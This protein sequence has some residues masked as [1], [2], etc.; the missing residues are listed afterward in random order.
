MS[1]PG[2]YALQDPRTHEVR[3]VGLGSNW[4][5]RS[6]THL[7]NWCLNNDYPV[8]RWIKKLFRLGLKPYIIC[9][10][11]F[12]DIS[13]QDLKEAEK[14]WIRYFKSNGSHLLN[15]TDGG[16]G[17]VGYKFSEESRKKMSL[18]KS[19]KPQFQCYTS[20]ATAKKRDKLT[21]VKFSKERSERL[22]QLRKGKPKINPFTEEHRRN[23]G[24]SKKKKIRDN[25]GNIY[26]STLEAS[27]ILDITNTCIT[28]NLSGRTLKVKKMYTFKYVE[29]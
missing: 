16:D 19:G 26:E 11:E 27:T 13:F 9:V 17:M 14:Y 23:I 21:G 15:C 25:F 10:Q 1:S 20:E 12:G 24:L 22:S 4:K 29:D 3:Y 28:N 7:Q 18:A 6:S 2:I 8:Y 5:K